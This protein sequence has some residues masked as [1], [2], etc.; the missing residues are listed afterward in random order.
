M[1]HLLRGITNIL[2]TVYAPSNACLYAI[3]RMGVTGEKVNH[4]ERK[5]ELNDIDKR[6]IKKMLVDL[7][8][9]DVD[10][11]NQVYFYYRN[12]LYAD[13]CKIF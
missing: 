3:R 8:A 13:M 5:K 9:L 6:K 1:E 11:E 12:I 4:K 7:M 10:A 2:C